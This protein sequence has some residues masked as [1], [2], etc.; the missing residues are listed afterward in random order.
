MIVLML[1]GTTIKV[2]DPK[3]SDFDYV[4]LNVSYSGSKTIDKGNL[5]FYINASTSRYNFFI[6]SSPVQND[7]HYANGIIVG[8]LGQNYPSL[9]KSCSLREFIDKLVLSPNVNFTFHSPFSLNEKN[10]Q[11]VFQWNK[12]IPI[13]NFH[14]HSLSFKK[15]AP[16]YYFLTISP[17][18]ISSQH[19]VVLSCIGN[20]QIFELTL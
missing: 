17:L 12:T 8:Y 15:T 1:V 2:I 13:Y 14:N 7:E 19:R 9:N 5:T 6:N 11:S 16:G 20:A 18:K 3:N 10:S 4:S